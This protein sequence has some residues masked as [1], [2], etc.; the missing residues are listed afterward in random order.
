MKSRLKSGPGILPRQLLFCLFFLSTLFSLGQTVSIT[1]KAVGEA[2]QLVRIIVYADQFSRLEQTLA[3]TR[4]DTD[5]NFKLEI[6]I[7]KTNYAFLAVGLNKGE[8]YLKPGARYNFTI[9][10][11]TTSRKGSVFDRLPLQFTLDADDGGLNLAIGD[12]NLMVNR[13]LYEQGSKIYKGRSGGLVAGFEKKAKAQFNGIDEPYFLNYMKYSFASLEWIG[14]KKEKH[15]LS[16]YF[17]GQAVLYNNIQYTEF[18]ND[19]IKTYHGTSESF[20]YRETIRAINSPNA[21]AA[22]DKLLQLDSLLAKDPQLRALS[23]ILLLARKS[24]NPNLPE[25]RVAELLKEIQ[26]HNSNERIRGVARNFVRKLEKLRYGTPA[27]VFELENG[28][29]DTVRI[30]QFEG[31]FVLLSFIRPDCRVCLLHF[32]QLSELQEKFSS[33]LQ[34]ITIVYG[35]AYDMVVDYARS[36]LYDWPILNL[37]KDILLLE[38]YDIKTY[39][40][41]T[42]INPDGTIALS[43]APMPDENLELYL[44]R[45]MVQY[46]TNH[47]KKND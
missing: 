37:K 3:S 25:N 12:Y 15:I 24:H 7:E 1:G 39:P 18:F 36:R 34:L 22:L 20:D 38:Q 30:K 42:I 31:R 46:D 47:P 27:P 28:T 45:M 35:P 6:E 26:Q 29:G 2:G 21:L 8:F 13:F 9:L 16:S 32:Q 44:L 40:T 23:T 14:M 41:Y 43:P 17:V 11:D 33:K 4:I 10:P 5:G 19:F